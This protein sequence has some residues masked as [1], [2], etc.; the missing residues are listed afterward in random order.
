MRLEPLCRMTMRYTGESS[1]QRPYARANG[2]SEQ[3]FGYGT[4]EGTVTGE[5]LEGTLTWVNTPRR[6]EDGVWEP[7]LRGF[8]KA[9]DGGELLVFF[10]GLSIDGNSPE[11]RR[12][13]AGHV[14]LVTEHAP[15]RW[16]NTCIL[17]GEGEIDARML[18]WWIDVHVCVNDIVAYSPTVGAHAPERFRQGGTRESRRGAERNVRT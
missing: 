14:S 4:G 8:I 12:S 15:L 9:A 10:K 1:W 2:P 11:P 3:E 5:A 16:V 6:R 18:Q 7:D 13:I 17:V